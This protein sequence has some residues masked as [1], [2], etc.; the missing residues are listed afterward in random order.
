VVTNLCELKPYLKP[1]GRLILSVT[2]VY[3]V[4]AYSV[5]QRTREIGI[6]MA[7]GA[8]RN[9]V[10]TLVLREGGWLAMF[11]VALGVACSVGAATLMPKL[12][13]ATPVW[14]AATLAAVAAVLGAAAM[15]ASYIPAHRAAYGNPVE[16]LRAE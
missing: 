6:R 16:A 2:G 15:L 5:G 13:F 4:I 1:V 8:G 12:L 10:C 11:V 3:G 9:S 14:D 7:L